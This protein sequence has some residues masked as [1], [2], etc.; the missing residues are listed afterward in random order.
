MEQIKKTVNESQDLISYDIWITVDHAFFSS[1]HF[2]LGIF[3][4]KSEHF[5]YC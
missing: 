2:V 5:A 3:A 1:I 4:M